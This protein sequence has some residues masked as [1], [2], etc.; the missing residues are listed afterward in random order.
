ML[1]ERV[2]QFSAQV[3]GFI[4]D[5]PNLNHVL[6]QLRTISD[7]LRERK[8]DLV[9]TLSTLA[10]VHRVAGRGGSVR[11][12]LQGAAGQPAAASDA[13]AVRRRRVQKRG[14]DPEEF[15]RNAGLPRMAVPRSER[16]A[17]PERC[18]GAGAGGAGRYPGASRPC[19]GRRAHPCSYTPAPETFA[20]TG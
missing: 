9:D 17:I 12:L 13:A 19:G 20:A 6:E 8:Y 1:L 18:S 3:T 15:W 16:H 2:G 4:N 11:P 14:I 5:N 10:Q 7:I